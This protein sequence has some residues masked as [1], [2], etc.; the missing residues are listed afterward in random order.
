MAWQL[1]HDINKTQWIALARFTQLPSITWDL[2]T[3]AEVN[4]SLVESV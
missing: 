3:Y 4:F 1:C 2:P